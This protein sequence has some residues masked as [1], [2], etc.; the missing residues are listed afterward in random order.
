M[1]LPKKS[2][3]SSQEADFSV[4]KKLLRNDIIYS[5]LDRGFMNEGILL[6]YK[7]IFPH[8]KKQISQSPQRLLRNDSIFSHLDRGF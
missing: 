1:F 3:F 4:A 8:F 2:I 5:H 7:T 6:L